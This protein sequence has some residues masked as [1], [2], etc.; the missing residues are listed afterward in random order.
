MVYVSCNVAARA[1]ML[2][3]SHYAIF[4]W[5][6]ASTTNVVH[7]FAVTFVC[8]LGLVD[9]TRKKNQNKKQ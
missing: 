7:Q 1:A 3:N 6:A 9:I 8:A 5:L 4:H 2:H